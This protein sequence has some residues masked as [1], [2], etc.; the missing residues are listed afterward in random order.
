MKIKES[1]KMSNEDVEKFFDT[2]EIIGR[3]ITGTQEESEA[4]FSAFYSLIMSRRQVVSKLYDML[5]PIDR[6]PLASGITLMKLIESVLDTDLMQRL[7]TF[8]CKKTYL[9]STELDTIRDEYW[10]KKNKNL[11]LLCSKKAKYKYCY[12]VI[13]EQLA[14]VAQMISK[15]RE[16]YAFLSECEKETLKTMDKEGAPLF[17]GLN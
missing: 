17:D 3:G 10:I 8:A 2:L 12:K 1:K 7:A 13:H 5:V 9:D 11:Y 6:K 14:K 15:T 4:A 16:Y